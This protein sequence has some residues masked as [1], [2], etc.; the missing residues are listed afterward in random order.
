MDFDISLFRTVFP[1]FAD[2]TKYPDQQI[3][4]WAT[5][6]T[7]QVRE[8]IWKKSWFTGVSLYVAHE[9]TVAAQNAKIAAVGGVPGTSGGIANTKTVGSVTVGYDTNTSTEE[10]AGYW[11]R[12][13]YGMQ[14]FRLAQ[15]FGAGAIQL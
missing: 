12:T 11:N 4:F 9:I 8:C 3:S 7:Q 6:A 10:G 15:I 14:F 1:E 13:T 2:T 5:L